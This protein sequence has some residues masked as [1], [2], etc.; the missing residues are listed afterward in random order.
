MSA[1]RSGIS[2]A[3]AWVTVLAFTEGA[4]G[5]PAFAVAA[6]FSQS[7]PRPIA[8]API[9]IVHDPLA[10]ITT[11]LAP[12]VDA[13]MAPPPRLDRGYVYFRAAGTE[14]FYYTPMK[15]VPQNLE[16]ILPRP[17]PETKAIDYKVR[18][19]DV[20]ALTKETRE[21]TPPV[22][23]GNACK[24]KGVAVG[25]D[26][27]GLTIGLTREGQSPAPR[28]FNRRDIAF[29]ILLSGAT[30]TL[31]QALGAA[32][33]GSASTG[34][35]AAKSGGVSKG[36]LIAGGVVVAGAAAIAIANN[37]GS[38]KTSTPLPSATPTSTAT[39][40]PTTTRTPT[41]VLFVEAEAGW[42]GL[43]DVD[44][45]ILD[46]TGQAVGTTIP[47]GCESTAQR[48]ERVLLQGPAP[49]TYRVMLSAKTCGVG[50]PATIAVVVSVQSSGQPKCPNTFVNVP[51]G[52]SISG[53]TFSIP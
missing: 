46:S 16:G 17:L 23:P 40:T 53:C 41:P 10:C 38:S 31:A 19:R 9:T 28:G 42:S 32:S 22:V 29:V 12:A 15:G 24:A 36:A 3:A 45:Q 6:A 26:G 44:V 47:V 13:Q 14:D 51:V 33:G 18:A 49:G 2:R 37:T 50:T 7:S 4:S 25:K 20:E 21:Y 8:E 5:L 52:G 48:T 11:E 34:S 35:T 1:G 27:A 39:P 30:V 43:G